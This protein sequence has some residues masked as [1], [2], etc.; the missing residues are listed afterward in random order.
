LHYIRSRSGEGIPGGLYRNASEIKRD[1]MIIEEKIKQ[2]ESKLTVRNMLSAFL[3]SDDDGE[4]LADEDTISTLES[5]VEDAERSLFHLERLRD[6][7][8]YL[9]EELSELRWLLKKNA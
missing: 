5:I 4:R 9:E 3:E 7:L 8:N 6:G 1:M 2:T